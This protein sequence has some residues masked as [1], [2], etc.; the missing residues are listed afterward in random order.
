MTEL[1]ELFYKYKSD[2]CPKVFHSYSPKYYDILKE[3]KNEFNYILEIGVGTKEIMT[4]ISGSD[5]QIG[6]SLR[7]W[8]D[9]FIN[10]FVFGLDINKD[11]L[12]EDKRIKCFY[13][14]QSKSDSL[15]NTINEINKFTDKTIHYDLIIDDGSHEVEHMVLTFKTLK[16][17]LRKGG[18]YIIEDIKLKDLKFF[19]QL[20]CED[21]E[22]I[23]SHNGEFEW[24]SFIVFK[25][26]N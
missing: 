16:E 13:T 18:L 20:S 26:N 8:R 12:F 19:E 22:I 7:G 10:S 2:K 5:Y 4:P 24:D 6:S 9:F 14:D 21:Y 17:F 1:C 3:Y 25:K 23:Y 11:V 15:L